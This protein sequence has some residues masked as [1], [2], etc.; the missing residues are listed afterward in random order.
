VI[1]GCGGV[2]RQSD[3]YVGAYNGDGS[4]ER[5]EELGDGADGEAVAGLEARVGR[6]PMEQDHCWRSRAFSAKRALRERNTSQS[7]ARRAFTASR[8][9]A[10]EY[11]RMTSTGRSNLT[12][13]PCANVWPASRRSREGRFSCPPPDPSWREPGKIPAISWS[14]PTF[15]GVQVATR[16]PARSGTTTSGIRSVWRLVPPGIAKA[17]APRDAPLNAGSG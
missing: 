2:R 3:G 4:D 8:S 17:R 14:V 10:R 1:T 9:I 13:P 16:G 6:G 5:R 11:Q 15:C 7:A 12:W